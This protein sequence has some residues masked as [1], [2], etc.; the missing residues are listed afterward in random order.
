MSEKR[1]AK[2]IFID[3]FS[4]SM[5]FLYA[6]SWQDSSISCVGWFGGDLLAACLYNCEREFILSVMKIHFKWSTKNKTKIILLRGLKSNIYL[7]G[8]E[9]LKGSIN[10]SPSQFLILKYHFVIIIVEWIWV[11]FSTERVF[12][13]QLS[14]KLEIQSG[15]SRGFH[16]NRGVNIAKSHS[17]FLKSIACKITQLEA[18][19]REAISCLIIS[20]TIQTKVKRDISSRIPQNTIST[21]MKIKIQMK[22]LKF[23]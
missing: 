10:Y 3:F 9:I 6:V 16:P 12:A 2:T 14:K 5:I 23:M 8:R 21:E 4:L 1:V 7:G 13:Y 18:P 11:N 20:C 17:K 15:L 19:Q 22:L